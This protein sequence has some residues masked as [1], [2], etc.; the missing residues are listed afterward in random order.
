MVRSWGASILM[1]ESPRPAPPQTWMS[2]L[3]L[4]GRLRVTLSSRQICGWDL[5]RASQSRWTEPEGRLQGLGRALDAGSHL[6]PTPL[7][8][9]GR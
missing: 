2:E 8:Q 6:C 4:S 9:G 7:S 1:G 5:G 3:C